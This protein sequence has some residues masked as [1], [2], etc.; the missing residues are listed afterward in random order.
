LPKK[1]K[2]IINKMIEGAKRLRRQGRYT[3]VPS[4]DFESQKARVANDSVAQFIEEGFERLDSGAPSTAGVPATSLYKQYRAWAEE[5]GIQR[6][7]QVHANTF[8]DRLESLKIPQDKSSLN[9]WA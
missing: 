8:K 2:G 1:S 7:Y 3:H 5:N 9:Y 6:Q 4:S